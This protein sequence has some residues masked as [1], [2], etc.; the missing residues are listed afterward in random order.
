M[1]VTL[2][3]FT[4]EVSGSTFRKH[5][6]ERCRLVYGYKMERVVRGSSSDL[7]GLGQEAARKRAE[8]N[9]NRALENELADGFDLV[10]CPACGWYQSRMVSA[11]RDEKCRWLATA[12]LIC[13]SVCIY[14][15]CFAIGIP[16][17]A[18]SQGR[19]PSKDDKVVVLISEICAAFAMVLSGVFYSID[20][21]RRRRLDLNESPAAIRIA[22]AKER[23]AFI[24]VS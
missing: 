13:L 15:V 4:C 16:N 12:W 5:R 22:R 7:Y 11:A 18:R 24:V 6:C 3:S 21:R 8:R 17:E 2:T 10:P 9:A 1:F 23:G 19:A 14:G 20:K